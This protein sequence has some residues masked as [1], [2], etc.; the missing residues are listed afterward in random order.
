MTVAGSGGLGINVGDEL[1]LAI[2]YR[3]N[4]GDRTFTSRFQ[5]PESGSAPLDPVGS[6]EHA[7][8]DA[9]TGATE[10]AEVS[11]M[12][13]QEIYGYKGV[14][15]EVKDGKWNKTFYSGKYKSLIYDPKLQKV[16]F[17]S[18]YQDGTSFVIKLDQLKRKK[19]HVIFAAW[20][21]Q[22]KQLIFGVDG[23]GH[24]YEDLIR[25]HAIRVPNTE[26]IPVS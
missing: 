20:N 23:V 5:V 18:R 19:R 2:I 25:T 21:D 7:T 13:S 15:R 26:G 4:G 12:F 1:R 6:D 14:L 16:R 24:I 9:I 22:K 11:K 17:T 8:P 3:A 10:A